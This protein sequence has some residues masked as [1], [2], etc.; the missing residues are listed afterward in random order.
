MSTAI[1]T[2]VVPARP[3]TFQTIPYTSDTPLRFGIV[4]KVKGWQQ[5]YA[6]QLCIGSDPQMNTM[7]LN[8]IRPHFENNERHGCQRPTTGI[9]LCGK[10]DFQNLYDLSSH[11]RKGC[12]GNK[13]LAERIECIRF[14]NRITDPRTGDHWR[15]EW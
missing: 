6:C 13:A 5:V 7:T 1:T 10:N 14:D 15:G 3:P 2:T 9:C 11:L 4:Y 12:P 8:Q